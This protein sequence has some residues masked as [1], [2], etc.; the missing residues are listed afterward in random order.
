M[1]RSDN[2]FIVYQRF[3]WS[4]C[5]VLIVCVSVFSCPFR[6]RLDL[7]STCPKHNDKYGRLIEICTGRIR[8]A[9]GPAT[10]WGGAGPPGARGCP[11]EHS[12]MWGADVQAPRKNTA[13]ARARPHS[14]ASREKPVRPWATAN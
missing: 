12:C 10:D 6:L 7:S 9:A 13:A 1:R 4:T 2:V 5:F 3:S 14:Y 8:A 11:A